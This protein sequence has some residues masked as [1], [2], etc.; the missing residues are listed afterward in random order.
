M[1][2]P[3]LFPYYGNPLSPSF[4]NC[5]DFYFTPNIWETH[6]FGIF[7]F[8]NTFLALWEFTFPMFWAMY[9]FLL[10]AND[11]RNTWLWIV[12]FSHSFPVLSKIISPMFWG[13][14]Y[15]CQWGLKKKIFFDPISINTFMW[16]YSLRKLIYIVGGPNPISAFQIPLS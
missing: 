8:S 14:Y 16:N 4:G 3:I 5:M 2:F 13:Q 6:K 12:L 10:L 11:V 15:W 9:G 7:A 1:R